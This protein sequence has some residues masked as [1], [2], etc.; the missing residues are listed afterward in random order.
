MKKRIIT[1]LLFL[2]IIPIIVL[3]GSSCTFED[4]LDHSSEKRKELDNG[5]N[6]EKEY[7]FVITPENAKGDFRTF[8]QNVVRTHNNV[9]IK[10]GTYEIELISWRGISPKDGCTITFEENAKIKVKANRLEAYSLLDLRGRKNITLINPTIEGDKYIHLDYRGQWGHGINLS[11]CSNIR[12]H[13]ANIT[14]FWGDG[15]YIN[16]SENIKIYNP[17]ISDNRRQGISIIS[18]NDIEIH[19][20]IV[21]NTGGTSPGY[22]IDVEPNWNGENV[23]GLRIYKPI[24]RNNGNG[25]E[26]LPVGFCLSTH[27]AMTINPKIGRLVESKIDIEIFDPVFEGDMLYIIPHNDQIKGKLKIHSPVFKNS[28]NTAIYFRDHQS[29]SFSTEIINPKLIDCVQS[30]EKSIYLAPILFYCSKKG[31]KKN[32]S[33]NILIKNPTITGSKNGKYNNFVAI[34]N[35]GTDFFSDDMKNVSISNLTVKGY[36]KIFYNHGGLPSNIS[37]LH[38]DFSLSINEKSELPTIP[39]DFSVSKTL[40][41]A[42]VN[43]SY[44]KE[45]SIIYLSREIPVSGFEFFYTNDSKDSSSLK[46]IFGTK[47]K[48]T[49]AFI[50]KWG[51]NEFSGIEIPYGGFIKLKKS[52]VDKQGEH[53]TI[54]EAS[55]DVKGI[56]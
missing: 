35:I 17:Y 36:E 47:K 32:G 6:N 45:N 25:K 27:G 43:H 16:N 41:G 54:V 55:K 11:D 10:N 13:N 18:G 48:P 42:T 15:I 49:K 7:D 24:F 33:K 46:L 8:F 5:K 50:S 31:I 14:K 53:W 56:K 44:G 9:L 2:G 40:N 20:L 12:I 23:T 38:P 37:N 1:S 30:L 39:L 34:R 29:N 3:G 22:G 4:I 52:K 21:E 19:N 28:K 26:T 51:A